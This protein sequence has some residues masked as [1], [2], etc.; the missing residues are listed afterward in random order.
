M[1][2]RNAQVKSHTVHVD[3][4]MDVFSILFNNEIAF[5]VEGINEDENTV[6]IR[7]TTN[8]KLMRDKKSLENIRSMV[9]D[10]DYYRRGSDSGSASIDL[11]DEDE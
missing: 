10:Y 8:T 9:A 1:I 3:V 11:E 5:T 2:T 6:L 7:T 4:I